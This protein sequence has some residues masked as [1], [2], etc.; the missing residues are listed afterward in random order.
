MTT[1][2]LAAPKKTGPLALRVLDPVVSLGEI[3]F[4]LIMTLTFTLGAGI[5]IEEEGREGARQLLIALIG[6]NI[7]WG[8]IDAALYLLGELFD[9]G[10]LRRLGHLIRQAPSDQAATQFVAHELDELL[11]DVTTPADR[12]GL[13]QRIAGHLR[14]APLTANRITKDDLLGALA[15]F[16]LVF[17]ASVPAALPFIF[18]DDARYA[19]RVSNAILLALMF[20]VGY[21]WARHTL[22]HPWLLG[23]AFLVVGVALVMAAIAL[24]G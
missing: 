5:I 24:G 14:S 16:W 19:L 17:L 12:L 9:R 18:M 6:C 23:L 2:S 13:Y 1:S 8:I 3:L 22:S 7:A 21:A 15:S 10:R 4:G 20:F 11:A